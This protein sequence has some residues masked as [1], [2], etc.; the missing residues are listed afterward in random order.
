MAYFYSP[1]PQ[2]AQELYS[3][4]SRMCFFLALFLSS[5]SYDDL[6]DDVTLLLMTWH[7]TAVLNSC[8]VQLYFTMESMGTRARGWRYDDGFWREL[9]PKTFVPWKVPLVRVRPEKRSKT[10]FFQQ[11]LIYFPRLSH[12]KYLCT[13]CMLWYIHEISHVN[14]WILKGDIFEFLRSPS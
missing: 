7:S 10:A 9:D 5:R 8:T 2:T 12:V 14:D 13:T 4:S 1:E 6:L 3:Q 11:L